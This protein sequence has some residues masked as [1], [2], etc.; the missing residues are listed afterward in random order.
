MKNYTCIAI[1]TYPHECIVIKS[2]FDSAGIDFFFENETLISL[3]PFSSYAFGG[4]KLHVH[5]TDYKKAKDILDSFQNN[6]PHLKIV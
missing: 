2:L 4:I 6:S 1:F 3:L 5:N